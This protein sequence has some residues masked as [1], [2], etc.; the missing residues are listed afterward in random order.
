MLVIHQTGLRLICVYTHPSFTPF[1]LHA[2]LEF[3]NFVDLQPMDQSI[4]AYFH[5]FRVTHL[6]YKINGI[7]MT[8]GAEQL[9]ERI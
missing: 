4:H 5:V 9:G 7:E 8:K 3:Q 6:N 2:C 1:P